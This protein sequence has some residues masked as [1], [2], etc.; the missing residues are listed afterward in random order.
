MNQLWVW[1]NMPANRLGQIA[2]GAAIIIVGGLALKLAQ[3]FFREI[4]SYLKEMSAALRW[5]KPVMEKYPDSNE[6]VRKLVKV[7][8]HEM[9]P[10]E[11][12]ERYGDN[13]K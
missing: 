7:N 10:E 4:L 8:G 6:V 2:D 12:N 1:L 9:S 5:F 3:W 11:K 13:T